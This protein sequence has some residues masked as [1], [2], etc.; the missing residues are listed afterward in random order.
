MSA[1]LEGT[2]QLGVRTGLVAWNR[3][4]AGRPARGHL[5]FFFLA[6]QVSGKGKFAA[7]DFACGFECENVDPY[8]GRKNDIGCGVE[9]EDCG[10]PLKKRT[11]DDPRIA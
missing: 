2:S 4:L 8:R 1:L 9:K 3:K 11:A 10:V 5:F 7:R 6:P